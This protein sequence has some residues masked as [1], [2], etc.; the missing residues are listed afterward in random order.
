MKNIIIRLVIL[1]IVVGLSKFFSAQHSTSPNCVGAY[2]A[3]T[4]TDCFGTRKLPSGDSYSGE[5]KNGE[6]NGFGTYTFADGHRY[7]G[8]F[9]MGIS[10]GLGKEYA[11]D[12]KVTID[13]LM[14]D[15]VDATTAPSDI[16]TDNSKENSSTK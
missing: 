14:I 5:Y 12:G 9:K 3:T 10:D 6:A 16:Q 2:D 11:S 8:N 4:W 15:G 7:E 1:Y 13:S